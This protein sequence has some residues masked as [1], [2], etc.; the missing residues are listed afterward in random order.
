MNRLSIAVAVLFAAVSWSIG[1][2][3]PPNRVRSAVE[4]DV[5]MVRVMDAASNQPI[6]FGTAFIVHDDGELLT[7]TTAAH[8]VASAIEDANQYV[9]VRFDGQ[10]RWVAAGNSGVLGSEDLDL[11]TIHVKRSRASSLEG[12]RGAKLPVAAA[13]E[14][15]GEVWVYGYDTDTNEGVWRKCWVA[16][17]DGDAVLLDGRGIKAGY[18][19]G[20]VVSS[21]GPVAMM[22]ARGPGNADH[23]SISFL[24]IAAALSGSGVDHALV[25]NPASDALQHCLDRGLS[26]AGYCLDYRARGF[27][28]QFWAAVELDTAASGSFSG[29]VYTGDQP[30]Q[31]N[32]VAFVPGA[33]TVTA[34]FTVPL[35]WNNNGIGAMPSTEVELELSETPVID[36][37]VL[38]K[39][40]VGDRHLYFA[41]PSGSKEMLFSRALLGAVQPGR[42]HAVLPSGIEHTVSGDALWNNENH[43]FVSRVTDNGHTSLLEFSLPA[44]LVRD[45]PVT[46]SGMHTVP[47][48]LRRRRG[49]AEKVPELSSIVVHLETI[50]DTTI[51]QAP[52]GDDGKLFVIRASEAPDEKLRLRFGRDPELL[53]NGA[54]T[55]IS[56]LTVEYDSLRP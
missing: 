14:R 34:R 43:P 26:I 52:L 11:A 21:L 2:S 38:L 42:D 33:A 44:N 31:L 54:S 47:D 13:P 3:E 9:E 1:Q 23:R 18:S 24:S 45:E 35:K 27:A 40:D 50:R 48:D 16:R 29:I 30:G 19:G 32:R 28:Y 15:A 53:T 37:F 56:T 17:Q 55:F 8:V 6:R 49:W 51:A 36:G 5:A 46:I 10:D 39:A 25:R 4:S 22:S 41:I 20:V 7:L 12:R